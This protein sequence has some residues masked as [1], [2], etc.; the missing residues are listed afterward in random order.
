VNSVFFFSSKYADFRLFFFSKE[1]ILCRIH[2]FSFFV[3]LGHQG[4]IIIRQKEKKTLHTIVMLTG[5]KVKRLLL[6]SIVNKAV[7]IPDSSALSL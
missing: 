4:T 5:L 7:G 2:T 3:S 6:F 1:K